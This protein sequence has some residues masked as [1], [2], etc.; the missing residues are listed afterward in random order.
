MRILLAEVKLYVLAAT[1]AVVALLAGATGAPAARESRGKLTR[2]RAS[3]G[4]AKMERLSPTT[5]TGAY[6]IGDAILYKDDVGREFAG[7]RPG[8]PW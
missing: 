8:R 4:R 5:S 3:A 7:M 1:V 2:P 6:V